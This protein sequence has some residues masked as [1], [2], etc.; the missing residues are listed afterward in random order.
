MAKNG[1]KQGRVIRRYRSDI[2]IEDF[3]KWENLIRAK[4]RG[5]GLYALYQ[6]N[7][8]KYVGRAYKGIRSRISSHRLDP[9][10]PFTHFSVFL[11]TGSNTTARERRIDDLEA[12]LLNII[13]PVP[14]WNKKV[15]QFIGAEE[16]EAEEQSTK[17]KRAQ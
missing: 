2:P 14:Q 7:E 10:K 4:K 6:G 8:L 15:T 17:V 3:P 16:L 1:G 12:L 11:V 13:K 9:K 5:C